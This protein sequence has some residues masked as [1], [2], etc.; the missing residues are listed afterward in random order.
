MTDFTDANIGFWKTNP[1]LAP[2]VKRGWLDFA[3]F[4]AMV[5]TEI[6]LR[7]SKVSFDILTV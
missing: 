1:Q 7:E 6:H 2:F 5:D 3:K 4:N